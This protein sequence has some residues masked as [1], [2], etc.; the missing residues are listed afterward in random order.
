MLL[1]T[2]VLHRRGDP[3]PRLGPDNV[4]LVPSPHGAPGPSTITAMRSA[5]PRSWQDAD[6]VLT[7][8]D[9][10]TTVLRAPSFRY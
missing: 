5:A 9:G 6:A 4:Q 2:G 1:Q 8:V 10:T 7:G 3:P